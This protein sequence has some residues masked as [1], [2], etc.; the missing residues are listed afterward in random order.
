MIFGTLQSELEEAIQ[1]LVYKGR[2]APKTFDLP[3]GGEMEL[4]I[5][6]LPPEAHLVLMGHQYDVLPLARLVKEIGWR[7]Y[8]GG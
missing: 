3:G 7:G 5:E 4:F 8:S 2:S 1:Q 6:I